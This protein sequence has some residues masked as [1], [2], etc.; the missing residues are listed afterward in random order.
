[1]PEIDFPGSQS[2]EVAVETRRSV[3]IGTSRNLQV[4]MYGP[5][6]GYGLYRCIV[7]FA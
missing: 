7:P 4:A 2:Q 5:T 1:M 6:C 3:L